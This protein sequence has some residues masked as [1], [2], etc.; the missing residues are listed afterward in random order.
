GQTVAIAFTSMNAAGLGVDGIDMSTTAGASTAMG[1]ISTAIDTVGTERANLGAA[2]NRLEATVNNLT[3]TATNLT[4][5]RSR[6]EDADFSAE[7]TKLAAAQILSQAST[8]ML[9]QANQSQQ[10]VLNLLR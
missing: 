8:A 2:Q 10:G 7:S 5:S 1:L 9:A 6:I 4:E 3:S